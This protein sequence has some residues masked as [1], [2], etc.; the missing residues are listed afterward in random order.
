MSNNPFVLRCYAE[1]K[2]GLWIAACPQFTLAAQGESF[3]EAKGKLESQIKSYVVEALTVDKAHAAE[4]LSRK[5]PLAV[6]L[7]YSAKAL[8]YSILKPGAKRPKLRSFN[9]PTLQ[10]VC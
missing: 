10:Y 6:R 5:A 3:E 1:K 9:E 7:R 2:N 4:L 8:A